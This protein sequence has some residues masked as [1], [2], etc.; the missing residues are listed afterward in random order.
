M[1]ET[2]A[3][4]TP[5]FWATSLI[6]AMGEGGLGLERDIPDVVSVY[7]NDY[8]QLFLYFYK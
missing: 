8:L 2:V 3:V 1:R 4:D 7:E 6:L 5:A